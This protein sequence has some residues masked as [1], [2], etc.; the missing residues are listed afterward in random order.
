MSS[1]IGKS[2]I[3]EVKIEGLW[4]RKDVLWQNI[5]P[6]I[7]ILVGINGSGK[8]TLLN[9]ID[10]YYRNDVRELKKYIGD[11]SGIPLSDEVYPVFYLR[12]YDVPVSDKRKSDSP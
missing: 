4:G 1:E 12:S 2:Y 5:R 7:N 6:D 8:T 3:K 9:M 11:F 10:A